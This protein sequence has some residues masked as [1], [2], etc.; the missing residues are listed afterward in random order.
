MPVYDQGP[1]IKAGKG[2]GLKKLV[3]Q[4]TMYQQV[5]L[6]ARYPSNK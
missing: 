6:Q 1:K 5:K 4:I 2:L 3:L